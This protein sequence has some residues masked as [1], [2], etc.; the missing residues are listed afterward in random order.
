MT[1]RT[2]S[3]PG[4][5]AGAI[6]R[7]GAVMQSVAAMA[8][9]SI[10]V[11]ILPMVV[12]LSEMAS[13]LVML[14][15]GVVAY[16]LGF[17]FAQL[18]RLLASSTV[19]QIGV[20]RALGPKL[21][22]ITGWMYLLVYPVATAVMSGLFGLLT[23]EVA[24]ARFGMDIP[25]VVP[26]LILIAVVA[27]VAYRG[28]RVTVGAIVVLGTFQLVVMFAL[29]LW[30]FANPGPGGIPVGVLSGDGWGPGVVLACV[31]CSYTAMGWDA[32]AALGEETTNPLR[33]TPRAMLLSIGIVTAFAVVSAWGQLAGWGADT[34]ADDVPSWPTF[35]LAEKYWGSLASIVDIAVLSGF[36][37]SALASMN[38]S[39]R[40]L[41]GMA[42]TGALPGWIART[43]ARQAP[44]GAIAV[45]SVVTIILAVT[46]F[47][48]LGPVRAF[49]ASS[50][51]S[52]L[53]TAAGMTMMV[54]L[55]VVHAVVAVTVWRLYRTVA[56]AEFSTM[57]HVVVPVV[58]TLALLVMTCLSIA[59]FTVPVAA[60]P[61][62]WAVPVVLVWF[63]LGVAILFSRVARHDTEWLDR[64]AEAGIVRDV[65]AVRRDDAADALHR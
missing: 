63:A 43:N 64:A 37:A 25:W 62:S 58:G 8:P 27:A 18:T 49:D 32:A 21:G 16:L 41:Y 47:V 29:A 55:T 40:C 9:T 5:R 31:F 39:T 51:T 61:Y 19:H 48:V 53:V 22:F 24:R 46:A 42:R 56:R 12:I 60:P 17:T 4:L 2:P 3:D 26:T 10:V 28:V 30:G 33:T 14:L 59:V 45:Q 11:V 36:I 7:T 15:A 54:A 65:G 13:P 23:A 34:L 6:G 50:A 44:V 20:S 57:R 52:T 1:I 38:V 35:A